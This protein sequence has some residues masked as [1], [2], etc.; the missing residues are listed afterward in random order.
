VLINNAGVFPAANAMLDFSLAT[1]TSQDLLAAMQVNALGPMLVVRALQAAALIG[2]SEPSLVINI[3]SNVASMGGFGDLKTISAY[4]YRASKA[5]LNMLT[6]T[7]SHELVK[8]KIEV[9]LVHPGFV[10]TDMTACCAGMP[11]MDMSHAITPAAS[12]TGIMTLLQSGRPL[13]GK[14]FSYD[15]SELPW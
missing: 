14:F 13:N 4:A 12:V 11:S 10:S 8:D 5:A 6:L 2:G 1:L 9:V 15:G 7:A 3:S